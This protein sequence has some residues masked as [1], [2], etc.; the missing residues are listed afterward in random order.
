MLWAVCASSASIQ[1]SGTS[2]VCILPCFP[3]PNSGLL[4]CLEVSLFSWSVPPRGSNPVIRG[5]SR[6]QICSSINRCQNRSSSH[7]SRRQNRR[8]LRRSCCYNCRNYRRICYLKDSQLVV[9]DSGPV[10]SGRLH[11]G[12]RLASIVD[13][14]QAQYWSFGSSVRRIRESN[15]R[16]HGRARRCGGREN[17]CDLRRH[18]RHQIRPRSR[19]SPTQKTSDQTTHQ[20]NWPQARAEQVGEQ[21]VATRVAHRQGRV[22]G[23]GRVS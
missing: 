19:Y 18:A 13:L 9:V 14:V 1:T 6:R 3:I 21:R 11:R 16:S 2:I 12:L 5:Q 7:R 23:Q 17:R 20:K 10:R 15:W 8:I 4:H 22:T